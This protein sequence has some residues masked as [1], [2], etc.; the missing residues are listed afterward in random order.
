[1]SSRKYAPNNYY[2]NCPALMSDGRFLSD[3]RTSNARE[4][5][6]MYHNGM[7]DSNTQRRMY[8]MNA[9]QIMDSEFGFY[10][11]LSCHNYGCFHDYP[12][13]TTPLDQY[14]ETLVYNTLEPLGLQPKCKPQ[15]DYRLG[16]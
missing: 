6:N 14:K 1:M 13:R 11:G 15:R 2:S 7:N 9:D 10:Q 3:Y 12:L 4:F 16:K 5:E 8:Q